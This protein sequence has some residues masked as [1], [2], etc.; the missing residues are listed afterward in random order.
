MHRLTSY[1]TS[2][3]PTPMLRCIAAS[4]SRKVMEKEEARLAEN[5]V[6]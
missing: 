3:I 6:H 4:E 5:A 2:L 1:V